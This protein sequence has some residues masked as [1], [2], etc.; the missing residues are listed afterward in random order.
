[1]PRGS[2]TADK[3]KYERAC[4]ALVGF[5]A[6]LGRSD[7][8]FSHEDREELDVRI[9]EGGYLEE[10]LSLL[11][12]LEAGSKSDAEGNECLVAMLQRLGMAPKGE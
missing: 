2:E 7:I 5:H 8:R 12:G 1:V 10:L 6:V 11:D 3:S 9:I 4:A